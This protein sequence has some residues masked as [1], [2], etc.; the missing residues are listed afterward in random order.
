MVRIFRNIIAAVLLSLTF[1]SCQL[2]TSQL[3]KEV[4]NL[5]NEK[6]AGT[7]VR[8]TNINLVHEDGNKQ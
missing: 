3:E 7:G 2:T 8:A 6:L 1:A 5:A 4:K